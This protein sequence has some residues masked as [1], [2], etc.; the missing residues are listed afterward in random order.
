MAVGF[1]SGE[2]RS[3]PWVSEAPQSAKQPAV[4]SPCLGSRSYRVWL[5]R[6]WGSMGSTGRCSK[7]S[8]LRGEPITSGDVSPDRLKGV[9]AP[10]SFGQ[11]HRWPPTSAVPAI[12]CFARHSFAWKPDSVSRAFSTFAGRL[13]VRRRRGIYGV[14]APA[15]NKFKNPRL[16]Y[17]Q[18]RA[19]P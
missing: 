7:V 15:Q 17:P 3:P 6:R 4:P 11:P 13:R 9:L 8:H 14:H 19:N 18:P 12:T 1:R 2:V 5:P 16:D 10:I